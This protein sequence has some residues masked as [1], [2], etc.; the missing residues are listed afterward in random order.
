MRRSKL[1]LYMDIIVTVAN[2]ASTVDEIAFQCNTSCVT[3]QQKLDFLVNNDIVSIEISRDNQAFYVLT[4][5]GV[6]IFRTFSIAKN[7][8]KLQGSP[9]IREAQQLV[10]ELEQREQEESRGIF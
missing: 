6:S 8:E 10:S 2:R 4:R 7:L 5:R 1:E 9:Q 3:L